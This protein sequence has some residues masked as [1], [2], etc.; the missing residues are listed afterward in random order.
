MDAGCHDLKPGAH[1]DRLIAASARLVM[2]PAHTAEGELNLYAYLDVYL[3]T[4]LHLIL[5]VINY[6]EASPKRG[7]YRV[8]QESWK[9][10]RL[11]LALQRS[12]QDLHLP[13]FVLV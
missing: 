3:L 5:A 10:S 1:A 12:I 13:R 9:K 6:E 2:H 7:F 11:T 8:T 4:S